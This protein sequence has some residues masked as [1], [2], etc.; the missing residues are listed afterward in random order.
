MPTRDLSSVRDL[1][2]TEMTRIQHDVSVVRSATQTVVCQTTIARTIFP[3]IIGNTH[4][5]DRDVVR[6]GVLLAATLS[7]TPSPPSSPNRDGSGRRSA[8]WSSACSSVLAA[9]LRFYVLRPTRARLRNAPALQRARLREARPRLQRAHLRGERASQRAHL[10]GERPR[11][12]RARPGPW[13][14]DATGSR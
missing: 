13:N 1:F 4:T 6:S 7:Q 11:L 14:V 5:H 9:S 10:R 3:D 2:D 12:Q 8:S